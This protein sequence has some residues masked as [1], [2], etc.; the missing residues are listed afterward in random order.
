ML[1]QITGLQ[2]ELLGALIGLARAAE[3]NEDLMSA[4][5]DCV[6]LEGLTA[7]L[8]EN[9]E[10][11]LQNLIVRVHEE[12]RK[13]V[14]NC[15]YCESP[16]GRTSDYDAAILWQAESRLFSLK[17]ALLLS[18]EAL[19]CRLICIYQTGDCPH[20]HFLYQAL[21]IVGLE[22]GDTDHLISMLEEAGNLYAK[23]HDIKEN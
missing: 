8:N 6:M 18:A 12:K 21:V 11:A 5:T 2:T 3:G 15:F 7:A 22:D 10:Q 16:C 14:P 19:A 17:T 1:N 13:L 23:I 4:E 20:I 9:Q